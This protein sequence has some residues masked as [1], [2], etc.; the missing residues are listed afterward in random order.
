VAKGM[1]L[2]FESFALVEHVHRDTWYKYFRMKISRGRWRMKVIRRFPEKA[3]SDSY[4]PVCLKLQILL[5]SLLLPAIVLSFF[6]PVSIIYWIALY[7][8]TSIPLFTVSLRTDQGMA[9]IIPLFALWRGAA[10][11]SGML[12]GIFSR[13]KAEK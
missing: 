10:L 13:R 1:K 6:H 11:L 3:G 8:W 2:V 12:W 5:C 7:L 9:F 4:T